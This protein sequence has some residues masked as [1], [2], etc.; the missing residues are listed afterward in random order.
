MVLKQ[1]TSPLIWNLESEEWTNS[2]IEEFAFLSDAELSW[3]IFDL[4]KGLKQKINWLMN[5]IA[6][7]MKQKFIVIQGW[8]NVKN[9]EIH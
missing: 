8:K 2:L 1:E 5:N 4:Q 9:L 6:F 7:K 3:N